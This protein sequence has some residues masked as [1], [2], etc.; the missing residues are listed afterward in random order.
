MLN[1]EVIQVLLTVNFA[2]L[3]LND[4]TIE[5]IST[6]IISKGIITINLV[7]L[8]LILSTPINPIVFIMLLMYLLSATIIVLTKIVLLLVVS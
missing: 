6:I 2:L 1:Y 4:I 3:I 7:Q 5:I 8:L